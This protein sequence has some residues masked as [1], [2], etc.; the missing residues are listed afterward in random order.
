[1]SQQIAMDLV[2]PPRDKAVRLDLT[3][4]DLIEAGWYILPSDNAVYPGWS[5]VQYNVSGGAFYTAPFSTVEYVIDFVRTNRIRLE[6]WTK[7]YS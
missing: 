1:M 6:P 3:P 5:A 2:M 4:P 7:G